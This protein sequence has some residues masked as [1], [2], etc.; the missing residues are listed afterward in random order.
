VLHPATLAALARYHW[1]GNVRELQNVIR[2]L[3][4]N[5]P[6]RGPVTPAAL[7][8][9]IAAPAPAGPT[10]SLAR[11]G[12]EERFVREVMARAGQRSTQAARELGVSRQGLRKLLVRLGI[13]DGRG[14]AARAERGC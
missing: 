12:F 13:D 7:P 5:A 1:P 10:L 8:A 6:P 3:A 2:A 4:V 9:G 11:R 14:R